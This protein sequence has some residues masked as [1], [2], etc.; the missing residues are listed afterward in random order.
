MLKA[1]LMVQ[2]MARTLLRGYQL[3]NDSP[4]QVKNK[5]AFGRP[6]FQLLPHLCFA[7]KKHSLLRKDER[8]P[9]FIEGL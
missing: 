1:G 9:N 8:N 7:G 6:K 4:E 2:A 5:A 3:K